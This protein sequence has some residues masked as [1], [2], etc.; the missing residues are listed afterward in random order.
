MKNNVGCELFVL[1]IEQRVSI[2][3]VF[4]FFSF[5]FLFFVVFFN[6][7]FMLKKSYFFSKIINN[8]NVKNQYFAFHFLRNFVKSK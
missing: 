6:I 5:Y 7:L 1:K 4:K 3:I 8:V 2:L